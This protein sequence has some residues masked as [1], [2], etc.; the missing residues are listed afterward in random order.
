ML[1]VAGLFVLIPACS[2]SAS[3][4]SPRTTTTPSP[5][6]TTMRP[7]GPYAS[8]APLKGGKGVHL[9]AA[10]NG[11]DL[12]KVGWTE[13]EYAFS[14]KAVA[15]KSKG[16]FPNDGR[17]SLTS[18]TSADYATRVVVRRPADP[19]KFNGTVVVEWLNVSGGLDAGPDWTYAADELVRGGY[20]WVGVSAQQIGIEGGPVA[21]MTPVSGLGGAGKGVKAIDPERYGD[22]HHPGDAYSYD[23]FTQVARTLRTPGNVDAL[24]G[25]EPKKVIATGESQSAYML[26]TYA[27]G[28]QPLAHQF[29]GILIHSRGSAAAPLGEPGKGIDIAS[30]IAG[31]PV[32]IRT[33]TDIPV[34]M[35]ETETDVA[36][37]LNYLPAQQPDSAKIRLWEIAGTAH[38]DND[39]LGFAGPLLE[40]PEPINAGPHSFIVRTAIHDLNR[41]V[42]KGTPPPKAPRLKVA[43]GK[44]VL[45]ANGNATGGI[46]TPLV[47]TPVDVLSGLPAPG[48]SVAC[49]LSGTTTP[50]S[51]ERIHELYP[52]KA[53]YVADYEASTN[54]SITSGFVLAA[55]RKNMISRSQPDRVPG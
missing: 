32:K 4:A 19:A 43:D 35:V 53:D 52:T 2:S 10:V 8:V 13:N 36:G 18:T 17:I 6:T 41:W 42:T 29:D 31:A 15:Y 25:L 23:I 40:C 30:T 45:D 48:A 39:Q 34:I 33:D 11:P 38:V 37:I 46:R 21:V 12:A 28:V 26:T 44:L 51:P 22:L 20:A 14:G 9:V 55:D 50:L 3:K 1:I 27:D 16:A 54:A 5:P 49:L 47:D 7:A 24:G